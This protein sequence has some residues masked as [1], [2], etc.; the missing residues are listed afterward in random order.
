[1]KDSIY[2]GTTQVHIRMSREPGTMISYK[3]A[4]MKTQQQITNT[5][6]RDHTMRQM[7]TTIK[8]KRKNTKQ[9]QEIAYAYK[10]PVEQGKIKHGR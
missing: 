8:D 4:Y 7:L 10:L 5:G 6:Q 9:L 1:M 3:Q 2:P